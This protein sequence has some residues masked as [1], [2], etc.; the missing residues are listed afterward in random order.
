MPDLVV[1][2]SQLYHGEAR[3]SQMEEQHRAER[4]GLEGRVVHA[5]GGIEHMAEGSVL[6]AKTR[7]ED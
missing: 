2:R 3:A 5:L 1:A 7:I 6:V 4:I